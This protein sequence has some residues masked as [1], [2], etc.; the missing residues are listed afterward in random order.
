MNKDE[1]GQTKEISSSHSVHTSGTGGSG[2]LE[3]IQSETSAK[4]LVEN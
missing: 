1:V 4:H 2:N 3:K